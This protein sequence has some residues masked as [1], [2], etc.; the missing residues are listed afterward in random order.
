VWT[1]GPVTAGAVLAVV[2]A[3]IERRVRHP[4]L[5]LAVILDRDRGA[6]YLSIGISGIGS[7]AVFLFLTYYLEDSLKFTPVQTGLAF[8]PMV[9]L[10]VAGAIA[11]GAV[12]PRTRRNGSRR[13]L[14]AHPATATLTAAIADATIAGYRLVFW[15]AAAVFLGGAVLAATL[16]RSGLMPGGAGAAP[17]AAR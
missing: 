3:V 12:L 16:F 17:A 8:L 7:F 10:L 11:A 1:L 2:F 14:S 6:A 13:Y 15:I 9:G 5:P 4:L